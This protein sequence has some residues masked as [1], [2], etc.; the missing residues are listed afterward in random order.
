ML[1]TRL[2]PHRYTDISV[3]PSTLEDPQW[4]PLARGVR[5]LPRPGRTQVVEFPVASTSP[6]NH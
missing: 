2:A 4:T 1:I 5:V 6:L 3:D